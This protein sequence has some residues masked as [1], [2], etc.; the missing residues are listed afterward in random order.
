MFILPWRY[1]ARPAYGGVFR[2]QKYYRDQ[3]RPEANIFTEARYGVVGDW[4]KVLPG[5]EAEAKK[6]MGK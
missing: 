2:S 6:L 4:K 1:R 3:Q 5:F